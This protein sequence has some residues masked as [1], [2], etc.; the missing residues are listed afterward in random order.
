MCEGQLRRQQLAKCLGNQMDVEDCSPEVSLMVA[1][2]ALAKSRS[3]PRADCG[4]MP[5][6]FRHRRAA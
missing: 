1:A 6:G 4:G 5:S 3:E 2:A